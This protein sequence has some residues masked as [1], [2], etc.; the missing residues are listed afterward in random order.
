MWELEQSAYAVITHSRSCFRCKQQLTATT[1]S[2]LETIHSS[3]TCFRISPSNVIESTRSTLLPPDKYNCEFRLNTKLQKHSR[4]KCI[5][6]IWVRFH[7]ASQISHYN[8]T[9]KKM[10]SVWLCS[11]LLIAVVAKEPTLPVLILLLDDEFFRLISKC[12]E[13]YYYCKQVKSA[14]YKRFLVIH[15]YS[16]VKVHRGIKL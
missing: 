10:S 7:S 1:E 6:M 8:I 9:T 16:W 4:L 15:I 13:P 11:Y 5:R 2:L 12:K 14:L 3:L